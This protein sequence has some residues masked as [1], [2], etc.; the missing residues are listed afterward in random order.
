MKKTEEE[1]EEEENKK[2]V[3]EASV[4]KNHISSL[5]LRFWGERET[6]GNLTLLSFLGMNSTHLFI[7]RNRNTKQDAEEEQ[8]Q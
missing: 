8:D 5:P 7:R 1:E 2:F 3:L 6:S 4:V